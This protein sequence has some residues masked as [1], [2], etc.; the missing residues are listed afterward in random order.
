MKIRN[1]I[2]LVVL[3][4]LLSNGILVNLAWY[5]S[6]SWMTDK[7]LTDISQSA[8]KDAY[9][10]F[11]Y[12]F[13]DTSYM[14]TMISLNEKNIVSPVKNLKEKEI[15]TQSGQWNQEYLKN[16]RVISDYIASM[17]GYKY[18]IVGITIVVDSDCVF[19]T[20]YLMQ[21]HDEIYQ[22]ILQLDQEQ[23]KKNIILMDPIH[24][25]GGKSTLSSDYVVP[26]V[27]AILDK[28]RQPIGYV[29][30]YFDYGVIE[31]MFDANLPESFPGDQ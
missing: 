27:R 23:L 10:A 18:Y 7:Y 8:M 6:S 28:K 29:V 30:L 5:S 17:N 3:I 12:L 16:K 20:S 9:Q 15:K 2:L 21:N 1:K 19:S 26:V 24:V 13:V 31:K 14:A 25:E 11:E 22:N 4:V